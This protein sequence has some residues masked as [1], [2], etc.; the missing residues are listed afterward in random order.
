[1]TWMLRHRGG[2]GRGALQL[3]RPRRREVVGSAGAEASAAG[4]RE[5]DESRWLPIR[6]A[7]VLA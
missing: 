4:Q 6:V 2:E 5:G 3:R 7:S 1:M